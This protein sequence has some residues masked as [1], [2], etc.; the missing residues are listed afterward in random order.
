MGGGGVRRRC[1]GVML[2]AIWTVET[3][4]DRLKIIPSLEFSQVSDDNLMNAFSQPLSDHIRRITPALTATFDSPRW[5]VRGLYGRDSERYASHPAL[6][7]DRARE[8]GGI[9][10]R[11]GASHRLTLA[12]EGNYVDTNTPADLNTETGLAALRVRARR[13]AIMPSARFRISPRVTFKGSASSASMDVVNGDRIRSQVASVGM[14]R[15]AS[16][17]DVFSVEYEQSRIVFSGA[18]PQVVNSRSVLGGWDR[19]LGPHDRFMVRV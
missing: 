3:R 7:D 18:V 19:D 16:A 17:H 14:M 1:L 11:F 15:R 8:R 6:N 13:L 10:V 9:S 5:S 12:L 4:A 2:L